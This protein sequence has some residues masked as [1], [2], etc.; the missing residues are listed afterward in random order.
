MEW[1]SQRLKR[2]VSLKGELRQK[3]TQSWRHDH[4]PNYQ[5]PAFPSPHLPPHS[6]LTA[7][8]AHHAYV[9]SSPQTQSPHPPNRPPPSPSPPTSAQT[10]SPPPPD[11]ATA[12]SRPAPSSASPSTP[13]AP[14]Q[15][16]R[17]PSHPSL[18]PLAC[19]SWPTRGT[20]FPRPTAARGSTA[21]R[22]S[23]TSGALPSRSAA[24]VAPRGC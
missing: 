12:P 8:T 3:H 11:P 24:A 17:H 15:P 13:S 14:S 1:T 19:F 5:T 21:P 23:D 2:L 20:P 7:V 22:A 6:P 16:D 4:P 9:R 18:S 10:S